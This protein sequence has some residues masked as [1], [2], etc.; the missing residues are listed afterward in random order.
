MGKTRTEMKTRSRSSSR[1]E[2]IVYCSSFWINAR[3]THSD[4]VDSISSDSFSNNVI[5]SADQYWVSQCRDLEMTVELCQVDA[6]Y[7]SIK[8][9]SCMSEM[10]SLV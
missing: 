6:F 10:L 4:K 8:I 2:N 1:H 7:D 3:S 5:Y 9:V